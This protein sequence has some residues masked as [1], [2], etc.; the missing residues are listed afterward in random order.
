MKADLYYAPN[1][2]EY[3]RLKLHDV[4]TGYELTGEDAIAINT[5]VGFADRSLNKKKHDPRSD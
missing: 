5:I 1:A 2:I 4:Q 3:M